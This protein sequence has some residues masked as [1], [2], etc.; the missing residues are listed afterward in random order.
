MD[1]T[2]VLGILDQAR[3]TVQGLTGETN[4][5]FADNKAAISA[6]GEAEQNLLR[7][8]AIVANQKSLG[9]LN[10]QKNARR[11]ADAFGTN[12]DNVEAEIV[13]QIGAVLKNSAKQAIADRQAVAKIES[14]NNLFSS[15]IGFLNDLFFGDEARNKAA[16]SAATFK[17]ASEIMQGLNTATQQSAITQRAIAEVK[18]D[19]SLLA[20]QEAAIAFAQQAAAKTRERLAGSD[21][22][23]IGMMDQLNARQA[24]LAV[25]AFSAKSTADAAARAEARLAAQEK[26]GKQELAS[27][28]TAYNTAA[29]QLG[30]PQ[31]TNDAEF[32]QLRMVNKAQT[33]F[34]IQKG[35]ELQH[36]GSMTYGDNPISALQTAQALRV[37]LTE[38]Q[39]L[40]RNKIGNSIAGAGNVKTVQERLQRENGLSPSEARVQAMQIVSDKKQ[41]PQLQ[42]S[43]VNE[44][45]NSWLNQI[46]PGDTSNPYAPPPLNI[47][48]DAVY[49]KENKFLSDTVLPMIATSSTPVDFDYD[50]LR[51]LGVAAVNKGVPTSEVVD[52]LTWLANQAIA[53]NNNVYGYTQLGMPAQANL[54]MVANIDMS[55]FFGGTTSRVTDVRDPV[56]VTR[57]LL[58]SISATAAKKV[59][60][61]F[62]NMP[63]EAQAGRLK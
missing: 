32:K 10:A 33:D 50:R 27:L 47:F 44:D 53:N 8:Q 62:E 17:T 14:N 36:S 56:A 3:S 1:I 38:A 42:L 54:P 49:M 46:N 26:E 45:I 22:Q 35:F 15:P 43:K 60:D 59:R 4:A 5:A 61:D 6:G 63:L 19:A 13:T 12:M 25:T 18:T 7:Q 55:G 16:A 37:P 48:E 28:M 57:D 51:A 2:Q 9:E 20:E 31:A 23:R 58:D 40:I 39:K 34:L 24:H 41:L 21:I 30:K 52:G 29:A 11:A